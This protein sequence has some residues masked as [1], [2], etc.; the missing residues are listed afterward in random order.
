MRGE[1]YPKYTTPW[2][3][4]HDQYHLETFHSMLSPSRINTWVSVRSFPLLRLICTVLTSVITTTMRS[5]I[6]T[7]LQATAKS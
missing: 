4:A 5:K 2:W 3:Q 7:L 1:I 6:K